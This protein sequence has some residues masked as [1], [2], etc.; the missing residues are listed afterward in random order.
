MRW[1]GHGVGRSGNFPTAI[2]NVMTHKV[3]IDA[4]MVNNS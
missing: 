4:K 1:P 3:D 2:I